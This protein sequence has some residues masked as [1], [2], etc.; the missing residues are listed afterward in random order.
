MA[1]IFP[2]AKAPI[3]PL[4]QTWGNSRPPLLPT[5]LNFPPY[6]PRALSFSPTD[7]LSSTSDSTFTFP[8]EAE[9]LA[10]QRS[11]RDTETS[12]SPS[13]SDIEARYQQLDPLEAELPLWQPDLPS[14]PPSSLLDIAQVPQL[15]S[16][17]LS[18]T[19]LPQVPEEYLTSKIIAPKLPAVDLARAHTD[20][21]FFMFYTGHNDSLQLAA[22]SLLFERGWRYNTT[23]KVKTGI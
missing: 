7:F 16:V 13:I 17:R 23:E 10:W 6:G 1:S 3:L 5:P 14:R 22:A 4:T 8:K 15:A 19:C 20:L 9:P 11:R 2:I 18:C 21:L 12:L